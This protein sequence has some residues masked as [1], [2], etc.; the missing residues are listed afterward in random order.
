MNVG[1]G[2]FL[3]KLPGEGV[4][5]NITEDIQGIIDECLQKMQVIE[6]NSQFASFYGY[7]SS[8]KCIGMPLADFF[9]NKGTASV[10][11]SDKR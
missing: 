7:D 6:C 8:D 4:S 10:Y 2:I 3:A 11:F 5:F 9:S 1:T